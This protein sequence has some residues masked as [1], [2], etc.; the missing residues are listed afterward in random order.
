MWV[1]RSLVPLRTPNRA[2]W[3][4][5]PLSFRTKTIG[6]HR[7]SVRRRAP[8][9]GRKNKQKQKLTFETCDTATILR[10]PPQQHTEHGI[11]LM[12]HPGQIVVQN[13]Q[14]L[15]VRVAYLVLQLATLDGGGQVDLAGRQP[16]QHD[17][18]YRE[19]DRVAYVRLAVL[20]RAATV[21]HDDV[22]RL[23][24][25]QGQQALVRHQV[26][27]AFRRRRHVL[28]ALSSC[29]RDDVRTQN[30]TTTATAILTTGDAYTRRRD[31]TQ[32]E[33]ATLPAVA[34]HDRPIGRRSRGVRGAGQ[35]RRRYVISLMR[36][37]NY[38]RGSST[39][40]RRECETIRCA[41]AAGDEM[42]VD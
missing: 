16:P 36:A 21:Q 19:V 31:K 28:A 34:A 30:I 26:V 15:L 3:Q 37:L 9:P 39:D 18:R 2:D 5:R 25:Q 38:W 10:Q 12:L 33:R 11:T 22:L 40:G 35:W 42:V 8:R 27:V 41:W 23:V 1:H 4:G 7:K 32:N 29:Q 20:V 6:R 13:E 17:G 14:V 24:A